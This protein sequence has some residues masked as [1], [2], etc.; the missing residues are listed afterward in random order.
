M[1]VLIDKDILKWNKRFND[2]PYYIDCN[3]WQG[4]VQALKVMD[5]SMGSISPTGLP[6]NNFQP[7]NL[8][9]TSIYDS[10]NGGFSLVEISD[11]V[12]KYDFIFSIAENRQKEFFQIQSSLINKGILNSVVFNGS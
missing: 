9:T 3:Y 6:V 12:I 5:K 4:N 7:P 10:M 1:R 2:S 11:P 8:S